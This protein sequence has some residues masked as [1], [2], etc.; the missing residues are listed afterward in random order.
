MWKFDGNYWTWMS[1]SSASDHGGNYG[2]VGI[3]DES[4][5]PSSRTNALGWTDLN[6]NFWIFG[7]ENLLGKTKE[8]SDMKVV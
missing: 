1:G 3:P 2:E 7:G 8:F 5:L 6:G 4:Y